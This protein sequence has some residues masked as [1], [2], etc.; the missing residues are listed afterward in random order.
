MQNNTHLVPIKKNSFSF[1]EQKTLISPGVFVLPMPLLWW[2]ARGSGGPGFVSENRY[3][4]TNMMINEDG[5]PFSFKMKF[6][7]VVSLILVSGVRS[8]ILW[9]KSARRSLVVSKTHMTYQKPSDFWKS[10][11][12]KLHRPTKKPWNGETTR[13]G[14]PGAWPWSSPRPI[15]VSWSWTSRR[16]ATWRVGRCWPVVTP[17]GEDMNQK[18][19]KKTI[20][21]NDFEGKSRLTQASYHFFKN[22]F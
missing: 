10:H 20:N 8:C 13:S 14:P 4:S 7:F 6:C 11:L 12:Q 21:T 3:C 22:R 9:P 19:S 5:K 15:G 1:C 17:G 18:T 2:V 16:T